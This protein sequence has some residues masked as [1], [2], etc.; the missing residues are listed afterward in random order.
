M[1]ANCSVPIVNENVSLIYTSTL[2]GSFLVAFCDNRG[3]TSDNDVLTSTCHK[4]GN[5]VPDP[6]DY[7]CSSLF[8]TSGKL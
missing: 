2:E 6:I 3:T 1:T 8:T 4:D 7:S 5:W